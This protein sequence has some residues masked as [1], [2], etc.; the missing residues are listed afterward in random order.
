MKELTAGAD[1]SG[2][3]GLDGVTKQMIFLG[4]NKWR[5]VNGDKTVEMDS[6][7][8]TRSAVEHINRPTTTMGSLR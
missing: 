8:T 1:Y 6:E 3:F 4:A 7:K 5:G 2:V